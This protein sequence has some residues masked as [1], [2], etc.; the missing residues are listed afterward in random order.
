VPEGIE[1]GE[2]ISPTLLAICPH[3]ADCGSQSNPPNELGELFLAADVV[4]NGK[5]LRHP[6]PH[7]W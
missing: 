6:S 5:P 1:L 7:L 3:V 2:R 4:E